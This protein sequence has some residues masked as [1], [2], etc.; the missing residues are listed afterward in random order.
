[1]RAM[2]E[3]QPEKPKE[4]NPPEDKREELLV[5][6]RQIYPGVP[7]ERLIEESNGLV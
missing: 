3:K 2:P 5:K 4:P 1:M 6:L 7:D